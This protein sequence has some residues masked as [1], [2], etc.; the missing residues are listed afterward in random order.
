MQGCVNVRVTLSSSIATTQV[1]VH[2][3]DVSQIK[4]L[5]PSQ[6]FPSDQNKRRFIM[7]DINVGDKAP[8][9]TLP[10]TLEDKMTLSDV[11]KD[12]K[13]VLAFYIF[14]FAGDLKGL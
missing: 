3:S 9:F 2:K 1:A 14:D 8:D 6:G 5:E 10:I 7:T 4:T 11:L 13:V 12:K